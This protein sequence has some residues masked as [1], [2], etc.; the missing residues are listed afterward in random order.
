MAQ[1]SYSVQPRYSGKPNKPD[2]P[3]VYAL[4]RHG[5]RGGYSCVTVYVNRQTAYDVCNI[6]NGARQFEHGWKDESDG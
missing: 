5:I 4:L 1:I 2:N 3:Y 6:L